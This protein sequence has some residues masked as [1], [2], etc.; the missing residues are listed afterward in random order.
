MAEHREAMRKACTGGAI[1]VTLIANGNLPEEEDGL[2]LMREQVVA[3]RQVADKLD[4][5]AGNWAVDLEAGRR[6]RFSGGSRG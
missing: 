3:L 5:I 6:R 4:A 2:R 1:E